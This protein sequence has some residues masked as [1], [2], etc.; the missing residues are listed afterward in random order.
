MGN[1]VSKMG[2]LLNKKFTNFTKDL[3]MPDLDTLMSG[4]N[5]DLIKEAVLPTFLIVF[6]ISSD[7]KLLDKVV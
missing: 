5:K 2:N 6:H 7:C 4:S 1:I 3:E